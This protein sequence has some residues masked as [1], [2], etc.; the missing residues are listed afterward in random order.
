[1]SYLTFNLLC[2]TKLGCFKIY[3]YPF[4]LIMVLYVYYEG[5]VLYTHINIYTPT[6]NVTK[7][8]SKKLCD[9]V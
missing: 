6:S 9:K 1:M 8:Y 5:G 7:Q 3:G 4:C 2:S